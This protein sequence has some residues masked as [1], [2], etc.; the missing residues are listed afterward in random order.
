MAFGGIERR[1]QSTI[2]KIKASARAMVRKRDAKQ[3]EEFTI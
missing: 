2:K 3:G 1:K